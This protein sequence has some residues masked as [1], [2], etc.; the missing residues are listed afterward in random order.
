[1]LLAAA[2]LLTSAST[3]HA[4]GTDHSEPEA[5]GTAAGCSHSGQPGNEAA[6]SEATGSI[7]R[8][9][10]LPGETLAQGESISSPNGRYRLELRHDGNLV[11]LDTGNSDVLWEADSAGESERTLVMQRNGNLMLFKPPLGPFHMPWQARTGGSPG[12]FLEVRDDG[13]ITVGH[14]DG[15]VLWKA[16]ASAP[17]VGIAGAKHI[18]YERGDQRVWL[19][20]ADGTVFDNYPVSGKEDSPLPGRHRVFSKSVNAWSY[21]GGITMKHMVRFAHTPSGSNI[22]FHSI[23]VDRGVPMQTEQELGQHRSAGCVRQRNDK[24]LQ[25]YEWA[26]IGTPVVVL[27]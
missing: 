4:H 22:G 25:L 23:P 11:L 12:A 15:R 13:N 21:V 18:V 5:N 20:D 14:E 8:C 19:F 2:V 7:R 24:A 17:D 10:L 1:M 27:A 9:S 3:A 26:P 6:G 16:G